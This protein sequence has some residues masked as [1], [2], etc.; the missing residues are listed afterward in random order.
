MV[1]LIVPAL[2]MVST[3]RFRSF[4]T[5]DL[6]VRRGYQGL[7]LLAAF[8]A[9]LVAYPHEVLIVMAYAY[10]A[11]GFVGL[12]CTSCEDAASGWRTRKR[13]RRSTASGRSS[14]S[15]SSSSKFQVQSAG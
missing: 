1:L 15:R 11:S 5:F 8:I 13:H 6:G 2:L 12:R 4:K 7:I 10:L 14:A 9:L 3:I